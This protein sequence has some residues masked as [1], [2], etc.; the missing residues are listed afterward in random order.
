MW[1]GA[2]DHRSRSS[3]VNKLL[4]ESMTFTT[5]V[6]CKCI[7]TDIHM[8][9]NYR[10]NRA[11]V[12]WSR[13]QSQFLE[14]HISAQFSSNQL[15]ITP[16]WTLLLILKTLSSWIRCVLL[17]LDLNCAAMWPSRNW[18]WDQWLSAHLIQLITSLVETPRPEMGVSDKRLHPKSPTYTM[19]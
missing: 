3:A 16:A 8:R 10:P 5:E 13:S 17:G 18:D 12:H 1:L 7:F 15:Q 14:G 19:P 4:S 2:Q 6:I 9:N 11:L